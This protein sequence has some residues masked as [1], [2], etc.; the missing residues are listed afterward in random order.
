[1]GLR[2]YAVCK[3]I[4]R[5]TKLW[6]APYSQYQQELHDLIL[7]MRNNGHSYNVIADYLNEHGYK[8]ARGKSF[9]NAHAHSILKKKSLRDERLNREY[10]ILIEDFQIVFL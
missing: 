9:K 2:P 3:V 8:T 7:K 6:V 10:P 1:M 4:I 5:T